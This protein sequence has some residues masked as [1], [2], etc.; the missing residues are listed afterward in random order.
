MKKILFPLIAA[1][2]MV[3]VAEA[4]CHCPCSDKCK[5][6]KA[7][8]HR[9]KEEKKRKHKEQDK[10]IDEAF[11]KMKEDEKKAKKE[12]KNKHCAA[13]VFQT[14]PADKI[15]VKVKRDSGGNRV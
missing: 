13:G 15:I 7:D 10:K 12:K 6:E 11:K 5:Q 3:S 1:L 4:K 8:F 9:Q 14:I 2:A